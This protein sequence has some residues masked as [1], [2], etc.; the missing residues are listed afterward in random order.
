MN[1]PLKRILCKHKWTP[2]VHFY[3]EVKPGIYQIHHIWKCSK[4]GKIMIDKKEDL[5]KRIKK[6]LKSL[7]K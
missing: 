4:C 3:S 6:K 2:D 7:R 5:W 1:N